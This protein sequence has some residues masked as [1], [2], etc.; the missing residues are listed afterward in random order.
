VASVKLPRVGMGTWHMGESR[1]HRSAE[2]AALTLRLDLG[3]D[4]VDTAEM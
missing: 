3:L 2:V 4:H 1:V